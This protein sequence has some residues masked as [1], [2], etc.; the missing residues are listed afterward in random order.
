MTED[1]IAVNRDFKGIWIP[2][3]VW[4]AQ[5][6]SPNEKILWAEIHSL[7]SREKGGCYAG[8]DYLCNFIGV[9]E[10][11]L[12]EMIS[13]LK[14]YGLVVQVSFDGRERVIKAILPPEGFIARRAEVQK[15][16]P[17]GCRK[18]HL[19]DAES[20]T[21]PIYIDN[22]GEGIDYISPPI[23]PQN[24]PAKP[25]AAK[26]AEVDSSVS[27]EKPKRVRAPSEFSPS[28]KQLAEKMVNALHEANPHWLIPR[29]LHPMMKQID[30]M[31]S[32]E[33][34]DAKDILDLFMWSINDPFWMPQFCNTKTNPAK[35]LRDKFGQLAG[36]M[37][38]KPAPK[39]RRFA[40]SSNDKAAIEKMEEMSKRAL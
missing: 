33:N 31:I 38:A 14:A 9:K 11:R 6:L 25:E 8:N 34:R 5:G 39:E 13:N 28:V 3:E 36:K 29:S 30:E 20:C 26:A 4:L 19:S 7:H 40:A 10:R 22:K 27:K 16:A 1:S 35:C 12:Q 24:E 15:S 2:R 23:P 21:P 32:L 17:L 18:V 37:N